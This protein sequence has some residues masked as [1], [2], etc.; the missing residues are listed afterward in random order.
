MWQKNIIGNFGVFRVQ[1]ILDPLT[2]LSAARGNLGVK[3]VPLCNQSVFLFLVIPLKISF[4][5]K[6]TLLV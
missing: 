3:N 2:V 5:C 6:R 4:L 1:D